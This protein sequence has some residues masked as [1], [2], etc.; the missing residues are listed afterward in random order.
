MKL[1]NIIEPDIAVFGEKDFQQAVIIKRMVEDLHSR[2]KIITCKTIR[3]SDGL[4]MSSRNT[5]LSSRQRS[6]A[7]ILYQMLTRAKRR[8]RTGHRATR[9][10]TATIRKK[11]EEKGGR[12]DYIA[13]VDPNTLQPVKKLKKGVLIALAVFFGNTR[14][15]DNIT[16]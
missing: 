16:L 8:F 2:V 1:F 4:A 15:I 9:T 10:L 5:F 12:I 11:I 14:L 6:N 7:P 3:E 13:A